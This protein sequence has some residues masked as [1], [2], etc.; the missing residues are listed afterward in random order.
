MIKNV[1]RDN[2]KQKN[3]LCEDQKFYYRVNYFAALRI[4]ATRIINNLFTS[5]PV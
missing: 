2:N 5:I 1:K 3:D 4:L